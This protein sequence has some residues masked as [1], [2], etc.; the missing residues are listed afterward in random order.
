MIPP[1][2]LD[3]VKVLDLSEG[4]AGPLCAKILADFGADVLKV[5]PPEGDRGRWMA[6]HFGGDPHPE[7]SLVFLLANLNKRGV[8]L[9]LDEADGRELLR[10]LARN[11]DIIVESFAPGYLESIG[12]DYESLAR[13]NP[14]LVMVSITPFGQTGPYAG[15]A[16]EEIVT[17]ALSGIMSISGM[18]DRE[19]LK[20]GGMQSQYEGGL[21][22][23]LAATVALYTRDLTDEGQQVD[24]SL[25]DVVTSTLIIHQPFYSWAGAVQG[26]RRPGGLAY[27]QVQRCKDGYFVWQ[28]GGGAEWHDITEFFAN[29]TL[30]EERFASVTGRTVHGQELDQLVL[31]ATKD[32]T[33]EELFRTAS[34]K[35]HMLFGIVQEPKDLANCPHL[36][37]R[38]FYQEVDHPVIGR[39]KV[40]FRMWSMSESAATYRRAA[41][42]LGQHNEEVFGKELGLDPARLATLEASGVI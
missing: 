39:I 38:G 9:N 8:T 28:T 37:A 4:L 21:N 36:H 20:H 32:R 26:R 16:S 22:G 15:Y 2:S 29:E 13:E 1:A 27:G 42:L 25:H 14:R 31:E 5:E 41:P 23:A 30:K 19:P 34:E 6:P 18:A 17:Y 11:T 35:Y 10:A 3:D 24:V 33:M 7:K 40:P 12:L